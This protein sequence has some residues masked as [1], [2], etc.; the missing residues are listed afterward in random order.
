MLRMFP[1]RGL[2]NVI[3]L[4][5]AC[6]AQSKQ[7]GRRNNVP[8]ELYAALSRG[9]FAI[10]INMVDVPVTLSQFFFFTLISSIRLACVFGFSY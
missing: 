8:E 7:E 10:K 9:V 2:L 3:I 6:P 4:Q 1:H 5:W